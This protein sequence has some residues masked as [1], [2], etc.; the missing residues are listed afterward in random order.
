VKA[1]KAAFLLRVYKK[2]I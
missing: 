1:S 2:H